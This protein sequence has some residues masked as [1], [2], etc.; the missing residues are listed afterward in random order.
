LRERERERERVRERENVFTKNGRGSP[1][2]FQV[3][4][5]VEGLTRE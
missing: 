3:C 2:V 4:L 5:Y 1:L